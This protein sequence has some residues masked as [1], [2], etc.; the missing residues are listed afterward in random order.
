MQTPV[1]ESLVEFLDARRDWLAKECTT[2]RGAA[3]T[4]RH[5]CGAL[6]HVVGAIISLHD[7][8]YTWC[9]GDGETMELAV[10]YCGAC[11]PTPA[12]YGCV[13]D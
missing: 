6:V 5:R 7:K 4:V 9:L 8:R 12:I 13:H 2:E 3:R 1:K 11:E 10:P